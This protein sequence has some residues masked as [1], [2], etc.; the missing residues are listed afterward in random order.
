[1]GHMRS[2]S[3]LL[4]HILLTNPRII[5]CGERNAPYR[6]SEDLDKL[7][8][9]ARVAQRAPFRRVRYVVDQ[10]NHNH[11]TPNLELLRSKRVRCIFLIRDPASTIRSILELTE[12]FYKPWTTQRAVDYYCGRMETLAEYAALGIR[13]EALTYNDLLFDTPSTLRRLES[14]LNLDRQLQED[15]TIQ[16]FTGKRGDP[17]RKI[18]S[19]RIVH[20]PGPPRSSVQNQDLERA[21]AQ[22]SYARRALRL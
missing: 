14:F 7:E 12:N 4:L 16:R 22:L 5:S 10:V 13:I 1:M 8:I 11:I 21:R 19:G 3:T 17:S 6:S 20:N 18:F 2:G 15:Y 9:F